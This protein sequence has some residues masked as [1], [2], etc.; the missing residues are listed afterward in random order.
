[1]RS[2][3]ISGVRAPMPQ[4]LVHCE[5]SLALGAR[6]LSLFDSIP[7]VTITELSCNRRHRLRAVL[8]L[9]RARELQ[10]NDLGSIPNRSIWIIRLV[11]MY[12]I[13]LGP[14]QVPI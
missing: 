9:I 5:L 2:L 4:P 8:L 7:Q 14:S 6:K 1:M 3:V 10:L 11:S 12:R 13:I